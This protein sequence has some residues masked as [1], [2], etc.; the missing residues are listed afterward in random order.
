MINYAWFNAIYLLHYTL[1][2]F[3]LLSLNLLVDIF[4]VIHIRA[5]L[6][7]KAKFGIGSEAYDK[8]LKK[9][10]DERDQAQKEANKML[11]YQIILY[12]ICRFP[13]MAYVLHYYLV[14]NKAND[15]NITKETSFTFYYFD[16]CRIFSFCQFLSNVIQY[17]YMISY[18]INVYF[19]Y[20]FNKPFREG[21]KDYFKIK[22]S[23]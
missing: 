3:I 9:K 23:F 20:R 18:S 8:V 19:F 22:F 2:D 17:L 7:K 12:V 6:E 21:T 4:L 16:I 11:I 14:Y 1:S 13:E 5:D 15:A 10:K